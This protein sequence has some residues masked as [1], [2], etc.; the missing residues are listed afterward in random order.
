MCLK[1]KKN[2]VSLCGYV[3]E[4]EKLCAAMWLCVS[5]KEKLCAAMCLCVS[6]KEKLCF[7]PD[8]VLNP[9]PCLPLSPE[10]N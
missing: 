4:K 6:K 1:K 5:K 2:Y 10:L 8:Y 9:F 3:F 7:L